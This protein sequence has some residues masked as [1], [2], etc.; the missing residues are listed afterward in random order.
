M[1]FKLKIS[2]GRSGVIKVIINERPIRIVVALKIGILSPG[3]F[4]AV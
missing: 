1:S 3:T 2:C 4:Q